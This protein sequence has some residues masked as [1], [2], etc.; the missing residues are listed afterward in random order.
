MLC[1]DVCPASPPLYGYDGNWTCVQRCPSGLWA[2]DITRTC[3]SDCNPSYRLTTTNECVGVCPARLDLYGDSNGYNCVAT[4]T[5]GLY[6]DPTDRICKTDCTPLFEYNYRCVKYCP[7]G[8]F[9]NSTNNC[10]PPKQCDGGTFADNDTTKCVSP[11]PAWSFADSVSGYCIAI[12]PAGTYGENFICQPNCLITNT[13]ASNITQQCM[14]MC[15]NGTYSLSGECVANCTGA[16]YQRE[17]TRICDTICAPNLWAD[18][19][20]NRCVKTCPYNWYRLKLGPN[21]GYCVPMNGGCS[22]YF[23]DFY[24]GDCVVMCSSGYW[25]FGNSSNSTD[26]FVGNYSC[27]RKCPP[28]L[29]G[30]DDGTERNCYPPNRLPTNVNGLFADSVSGQFVAE[31]P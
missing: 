31:C 25:G 10:V 24:T 11:C 7:K 15:P 21:K 30:Y 16:T 13:F 22:P 5:N 17:D 9:A 26:T 8:F 2:D 4:C 14:S 1:V 19:N 3:V 27:L 23:A 20:T 18:P 29:Y 6:A 12:C 28:G